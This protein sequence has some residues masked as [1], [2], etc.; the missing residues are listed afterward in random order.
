MRLLDEYKG[1][2]QSDAYA[3]YNAPA[4]RDGVIHVGC[5]DHARRKFARR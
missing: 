2:L 4:R 3:G 1:Y 5:L